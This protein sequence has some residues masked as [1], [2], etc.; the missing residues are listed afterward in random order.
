G[1]TCQPRPGRGA[2]HRPESADVMARHRLAPRSVLNWFPRRTSPLSTKRLGSAR[3][4]S[5]GTMQQSSR[6][7]THP[8]PAVSE[9]SRQFGALIAAEQISCQGLLSVLSPGHCPLFHVLRGKHAIGG[10]HCL[11]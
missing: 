8:V 2:R 5:G 9:I 4:P 11:A 6:A 10:G 3:L 7:S 1:P